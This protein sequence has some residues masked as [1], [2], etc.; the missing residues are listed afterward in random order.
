MPLKILIFIPTY[1]ERDNAPRMCEEIHRLGLHA[2]VLFVDDNSPDGTG[3]SLE[4]LKP[5]FPRLIVHHRSG[6]LGVGSAHFEAI[7]WAYDQG[8][9]LMVTMD[10]DFSHSPSDIPAMIEAAQQGDVA[11]GSRWILRK[12]LPGWNLFR[13]SM[14]NLGHL[15]TLLV[16]GIPQDASGAFRGYHLERIPRQLFQLIKSRGYAFFFE[17]L[18]VLNRNNFDI[19]EVPIVLPARTY[20]HSKMSASAA[21]RSARYIFELA[22]A[23]LCCPESF[24]IDREYPVTDPTLSDPQQW[25]TYWTVKS[26]GIV[27]F[28]GLIAGLYRRAIIKRNLNRVIQREFTPNSSL[29]HAGCGSGQVDADIRHLM[30]LTAL[31]ISPAAL[32]LYRRN[33]P[34]AVEVSHGSIF[35]LPFPDASFDGVYNLGL[36]DHFTEEEIV[37]ILREFRR[38]LRSSGK[39]VLF[40]PHNHASSVFVLK[41]AHFFLGRLMKKAPRL[42]PAE[43]THCRGRTQMR[44]FLKAAGLALQ[45]YRFGPAD[46]FVQAVVVA[47]KT[48]S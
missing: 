10:C 35:N 46:F 11:V 19:R 32:R 2:D 45:S 16:L 43:I 14:T 21:F 31:D 24:V 17:S 42:H 13:R 37:Q 28:Y 12:S 26:G 38:V 9:Q 27:L 40:W 22:F 18:F 33:N 44:G 36:M 7:N 8:Y 5:R 41:A 20:G 1:N 3:D 29:L 4:E 47:S 25:D 15:L 23:Y 6:K 39:I 48:G 34:V 30:H